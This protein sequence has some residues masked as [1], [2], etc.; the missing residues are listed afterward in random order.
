M[1]PISLARTSIK[2]LNLSQPADLSFTF[3][4]TGAGYLSTTIICFCFISTTILTMFFRPKTYTARYPQWMVG[5]PLLYMSSALASLGDAMFGYGQGSIASAQV[6][7]SFIHRMF[8]KEVTMAQI[9]AGHTGVDPFT[10]AIT[11][12]CLNLTALL[13]S[14]IA[15]YLCDLLGR[16]MSVRIGGVMYFIAALI[17]VFAPNLGTLIAGRCIQGLGVGILSMTVPILQCE[18][19]PA[20]ARGL[21]VGIEYIC[22]NIG[23]AVSA[24]VGYGFF[25]AMPSEISWRGPYIVQAAIALV[26]IVWTFFL[27]ETPRWLAQNGFQK[28]AL[29]TLADLHGAGNVSDPKILAT[30]AEIVGAMFAQLNGINA[31]LYFLPSNLT[32]AGFTISRSLLYSGACAL[33]YCSG[34]I[35]AMFLIDKLGRRAFLLFGSVALAAS[36]S[37]VGGL[38]YYAD[39][40]P[41]GSARVSAADAI[42][43]GVCLYLFIFGATWGPGPWLLGA[44]IFPLRARAKGMSL[45]TCTNWLFNFIVAFI[46]PPLFNAINAGYYFVL[47]GFCIISLVVVWFIYPETAHHTLEDLGEVFGDK[48]MDDEGPAREKAQRSANAIQ[49]ERSGLPIITDS[50]VTL[51][52]SVSITPTAKDKASIVMKE[53]TSVVMMES[54]V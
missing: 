10:Q 32:R 20:H 18:I 13:A 23:Y 12:S 41:L 47:V 15:A 44:E 26:L 51:Q 17:Q 1:F 3:Y 31:I 4:P 16:R 9:Q 25:F 37:I 7:P 36:L 22:L 5:R 30:Y 8:G 46:T 6:Q 35:P 34:T 29:I 14:F 2:P 33:I 27:P 24:W 21:F 50:E 39:S 38:Q 52:P 54:D 11:V 43:F 19:A 45:S 42:F 53:R 40:L 49:R 48:V 28:E